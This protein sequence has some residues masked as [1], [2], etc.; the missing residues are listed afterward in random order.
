MAKDKRGR[1]LPKGIRQRSSDYEGRFMYEGKTYTVHAS[2]ITETTRLMEETRRAVRRGEYVEKSP[3]TFGGYF[4]QWLN[5]HDMKAGTRATYERLANSWI[6][7]TIGKVRIVNLVAADFQRIYSEMVD[8]NKSKSYIDHC[9]I[10]INGVMKSAVEDGIIRENPARKPKLPT[11]NSAAGKRVKDE[12]HHEALTKDEQ[13]LF[14]K[15]SAGSYLHNYF[16]VMMR[17]GLRGGELLGLKWSDID[18]EKKVLYIRRTLKEDGHGGF[19]EDT[20][21]TRASVRDIPLTA[22]VMRMLEEQRVFWGFKITGIGKTNERYL[23]CND[24]GGPLPACE[25]R[26]EMRTII[27]AIRADGYDFPDITPHSLRHTFATRAIEAGMN[28]QVLKTILGHSKLATT[29]DLY[30]HVMPDTKA[31]EMKK[32][33]V[34]F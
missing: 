7:P 10:I 13:A 4:N 19:F 5:F 3:L 33:A 2:T 1:T 32:I 29:M 34:A 21:K 6:L 26:R 15:Y 9:Y 27:D 8:D 22:N 24:H 20:P 14:E 28:P 30:S 23:F 11:K 18:K 25:T 16:S 12:T 17:T 31:E